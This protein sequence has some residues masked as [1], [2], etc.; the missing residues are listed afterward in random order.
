VGIE[1]DEAQD[2]VTRNPFRG[3]ATAV[4]I[5]AAAPPGAPD[6]L[7]VNPNSFKGSPPIKPG[8]NQRIGASALRASA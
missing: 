1:F 8:Y 3:T 7:A 2:C 5:Q 4:Q 6:H